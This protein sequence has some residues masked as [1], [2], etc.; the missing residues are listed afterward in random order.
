MRD[1]HQCS[2]LMAGQTGPSHW[3]DRLLSQTWPPSCHPLLANPAIRPDRHPRRTASHDV[4]TMFGPSHPY[5][6]GLGY[7]SPTQ[8]LFLPYPYSLQY[9]ITILQPLQV[10][11]ITYPYTFLTKTHYWFVCMLLPCINC[12]PVSALFLA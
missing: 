11:L 9:P 3:S 12:L 1:L 4:F 2:G 6:T 10:Q 5:T 8:T 7:M